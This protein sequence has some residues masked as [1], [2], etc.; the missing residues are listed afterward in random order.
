LEITAE[1]KKKYLAGGGVSCPFC[2]DSRIEGG[3]VETGEGRATQ[4]MK[5]TE[6][7]EDWIDYYRLV[8]IA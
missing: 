4:P 1:Q 5:C 6:C 8:D 2:G 7:G 3:F